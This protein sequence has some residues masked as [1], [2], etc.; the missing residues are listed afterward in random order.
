M[1]YQFK[2]VD[3]V[4]NIGNIKDHPF[5]SKIFRK[6]NISYVYVPGVKKCYF[7]ENFAYE[8]NG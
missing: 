6:T 8:P 7:S 1:N 3:R 5:S 4:L 2:S